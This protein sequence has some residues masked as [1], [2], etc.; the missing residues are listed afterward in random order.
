MRR[1]STSV[2]KYKNVSVVHMKLF[3][4]FLYDL[5]V[6][7]QRRRID[8]FEENRKRFLLLDDLLLPLVHRPA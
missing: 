3:L 6:R 1:L 5:V 2:S 7:A 4:L 8:T